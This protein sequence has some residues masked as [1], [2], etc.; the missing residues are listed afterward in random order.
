MAAP[1]EIEMLQ[2]SIDSGNHDDETCAELQK[3]IDELKHKY[4]ELYKMA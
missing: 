3:K 2:N 4:N 1:T